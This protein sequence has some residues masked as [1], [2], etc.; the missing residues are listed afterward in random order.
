M[1]TLRNTELELI[2]FRLRIS[3]AL[4]VIV[5][6]FGLLV[7]WLLLMPQRTPVNVDLNRPL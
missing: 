1:T 6:V 2:A 3:V 4:S 7:L 5:V